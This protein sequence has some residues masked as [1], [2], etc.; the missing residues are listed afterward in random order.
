MGVVLKV[1]GFSNLFI[2]NYFE[3]LPLFMLDT[4][5]F[6]FITTCTKQTKNP[7]LSR[8]VMTMKDVLRHK[9]SLQLG[10]GRNYIR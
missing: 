8:G 6:H 3:L 1:P 9:K 5:F 10:T 7:L 4:T 2:L